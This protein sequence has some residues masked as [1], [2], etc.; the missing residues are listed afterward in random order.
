[1]LQAAQQIEAEEKA[2][3]E[4]KAKRLKDEEERKILHAWMAHKSDEGLVSAHARVLVVCHKMP[5]P[6][7]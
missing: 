4:A 2:A 3:A 6:R 7:G 5:K 1:M